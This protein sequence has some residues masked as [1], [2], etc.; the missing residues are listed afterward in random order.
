MMMMM[1][2][3]LMMIIIMMITSA[4]VG[5]GGGGGHQCRDEQPHRLLPVT[6]MLQPLKFDWLFIFL[7]FLTFSTTD[8]SSAEDQR[9]HNSSKVRRS[10]RLSAAHTRIV[11]GMFLQ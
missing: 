4:E 7:F 8:T 10:T 9:R 6:K 2:M 3:M 11:D 5:E 1:M